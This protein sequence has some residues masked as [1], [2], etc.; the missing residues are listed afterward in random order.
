MHSA[1][2][3]C[4]ACLDFACAP[5]MCLMGDAGLSLV[6]LAACPGAWSD[7]RQ[8]AKPNAIPPVSTTSFSVAG[9]TSSTPLPAV[10]HPIHLHSGLT[11]I[12]AR[13]Q[14]LSRHSA[15][16]TVHDALTGSAPTSLFFHLLHSISVLSPP[17]APCATC[18]HPLLRQ[19]IRFTIA[20]HS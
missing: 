20:Y 14:R 15:A 6:R 12:A 8:G 4:K 10:A 17:A 3:A 11:L 19:N 16:F 7:R 9:T 18:A 2:C 13:A 5:S 1:S